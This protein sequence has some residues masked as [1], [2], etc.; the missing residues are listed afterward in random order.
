MD[1]LWPMIIEFGRPFPTHS[2]NN[3]TSKGKIPVFKTLKRVQ[4]QNYSQGQQVEICIKQ[5]S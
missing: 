5:A 4:F 3:T 1:S 2:S